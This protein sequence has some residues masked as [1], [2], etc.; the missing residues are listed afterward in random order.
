MT[1]NDNEPETEQKKSTTQL[2][3]ELVETRFWG[4]VFLLFVGVI[5]ISFFGFDIQ[6]PRSVKVLSISSALLAPLGYYSG[7]YLANK[8]ISEN[9]IWL[10]DLDAAELDG[11]IF[12]FPREDFN[13]LTVLNEKG[14]QSSEYK[15]TQ[16]TPDLYVGKDVDLE[17]LTVVGTWRGSMSDRDLCVAFS[18]I[19]DCRGQ[20]LED[21]QRG[22]TIEANAFGIIRKSVRENTKSIV[23]TFE[24]GTL[25]DD[26]QQLNRAIDS[27]LSEFGIEK[28][29]ADLDDDLA[30]DLADDLDDDQ[31]E[32]ETNDLEQPQ[33]QPQ[34]QPQ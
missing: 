26:G 8:I 6:I 11:G 23:E 27:H 17:N 16:L 33:P 32:L 12:V 20:L 24:K 22:F 2:V 29:L 10:V 3:F 21:A 7:T 18:A 30:D 5:L 1:Q 31:G 13:E 34:P 25:P 4:L 9:H 28:Q 19:R 15:I 14:E